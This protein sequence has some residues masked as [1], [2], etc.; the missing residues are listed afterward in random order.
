ML[1]LN[2]FSKS[3]TSTIC[4]KCEQFVSQYG[5]PTA[6]SYCNIIAAFIGQKCQRCANSERKYGPPVTCDQCKQNCAFNRKDT[7]CEVRIKFYQYVKNLF[8]MMIY[9]ISVA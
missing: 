2:I 7:D 4:K 1:I 6:C 9:F 3:N 8:L 5:R